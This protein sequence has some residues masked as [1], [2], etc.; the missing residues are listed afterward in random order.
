M[1]PRLPLPRFGRV[2]CWL[3]L[4]FSVVVGVQPL[5]HGDTW[6]DRVA[7]VLLI[8]GAWIYILVADARL[9]RRR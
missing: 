9:R 2:C 5:T 7:V 3:V 4:A 1:K 8:D 6:F